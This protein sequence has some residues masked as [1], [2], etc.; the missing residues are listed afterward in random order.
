MEL[1]AT[2][3]P[4]AGDLRVIGAAMVISIDL[5]RVAHHAE[6][7]ASAALRMARQ[8]LLKPL[9]DVPRLVEVVQSMLKKAMEAFVERDARKA[10]EVAA[11][12]DVVDGLRSQCSVNC[13]PT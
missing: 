8:P 9:I 13:L 1:V 6:G 2:Q 10:A 7:I 5:E 12:D 4:M 11:D 3:Q